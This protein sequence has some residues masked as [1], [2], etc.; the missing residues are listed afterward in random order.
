MQAFCNSCGNPLPSSARFCSTCGTA[1]AGAPADYGTAGYGTY[2]YGPGYAAPTSR[3]FRPIYG[4]Q[5]AG[6]CAAFARAYGWD[7]GLVRIITV[8]TA[9]F[10]CP[11]TEIIYL[12]A[13]IGI[14]EEPVGQVGTGAV[15]TGPFGANQPPL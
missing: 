2:G 13:W 5:M 9:V 11:I 7:L 1:V 12:A 8:V 14:P 10:L 15:G 6:V 4:R 3:L